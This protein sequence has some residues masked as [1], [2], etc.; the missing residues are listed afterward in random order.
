[1]KKKQ[2]IIVKLG[3]SAI[4]AKDESRP[5]VNSK[6]LERLAGEIAKAQKESDIALFIVHGAGAFGHVPAKKYELNAGLKNSSQIMGISETHQGME[7]LNY[8]VVEAL[9]KKG[10]PAI[11]LQPSAGGILRNGKLIKF[12]LEVIEKMLAIGLVPVSYGDVLLDEVKGVS[13]LSGDHLVPYL[14]EKLKADRVILVADVP[15]IFDIDPKKDQNAKI[16]KELGRKSIRQIKEIGSA[17]G[18]DVTGGMKGK[19]EEL[20]HLADMGIESEIISGFA[21]SDLK[22]ALCALRC[23]SP[24]GVSRS[25]SPGSPVPP[26]SPRRSAAGR[27]TSASRCGSR[28]HSE[29]CDPREAAALIATL[30]AGVEPVLITYL[31]TAHEIAEL[32]C[33]VGAR[34][35]QLHGNPAPD[36]VARLRRIA[37]GLAAWAA[38]VVGAV[39][40]PLLLMRLERLAPLV[41]AFVTDTFDP[42]TGAR[43]VTGRTH[44][45][46][47]SAR[48]AACS[49][50]PLILAGGLTPENVADAVAAVRPAGVD[51]HTGVED[52]AGRKGS[53]ARPRL[54][55]GRARG[56]APRGAG[57]VNRIGIDLGGTK[58]E[59]IA[60]RPRRDRAARAG[61]CRRRAATT[62]PR[63]R[64]WRSWSTASST[65]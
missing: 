62:T 18:T 9:R 33:E 58:I 4:T 25:R 8:A 3:G 12:P 54:R 23:G 1:M 50:R 35:V 7:E 64:R 49:P 57:P 14:A 56:R 19:L 32:A 27:R 43:G 30:P 40:E 55:R 24:A 34:T 45:W 61:A 13:I 38:L 51:A 53:G 31:E 52:A 63:W 22:R 47:V 59:A 39:P 20:L 42:R 48:L 10:I 16:I 11:A 29:D 36:E 44:D 60:L 28:V 2:F 46:S 17:K 21:P 65:R 6:N 41:D 37:P 5:E 26:T 15:G